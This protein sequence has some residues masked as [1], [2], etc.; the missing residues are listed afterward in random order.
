MISDR[1]WTDYL[2]ARPNVNMATNLYTTDNR[3]MLKNQTV[4][5]NFCIRVDDDAIG[6]RQKQPPTQLT[7]QGNIR[8][9]NHAPKAVL[10]HT[11]FAYYFPQQAPSLQYA[12]VSPN[13]HE[14]L[15]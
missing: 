12:L 3:H 6:M 4:W 15:P 10:K 13:G 5:T 7:V 11:P 1:Y 14:Q 8:P 2:G 9:C